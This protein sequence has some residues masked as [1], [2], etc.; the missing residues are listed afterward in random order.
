MKREFLTESDF[1]KFL[2]TANYAS[3]EEVNL[4]NARELKKS[5]KSFCRAQKIKFESDLGNK[6]GSDLNMCMYLLSKY[7]GYIMTY[8]GQGSIHFAF[9][10]PK[11]VRTKGPLFD[12]NN[13]PVVVDGI[14]QMRDTFAMKLYV[15]DPAVSKIEGIKYFD[16]KLENFKMPNIDKE[17]NLINQEYAIFTS[18][19]PRNAKNSFVDYIKTREK[20]RYTLVCE[21]TSDF[22]QTNLKSR[23]FFIDTAEVLLKTMRADSKEYKTAIENIK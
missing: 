2:E 14:P 6:T 15:C 3:N 4:E 1:E 22:N 20:N 16:I 23:V 13:Q 19:N 11:L 8:K 21:K 10:Y 9:V 5:I 18:L 12:E 7:Y 17:G